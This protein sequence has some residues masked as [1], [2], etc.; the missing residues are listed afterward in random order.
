M[1]IPVQPP[2]IRY[3]NYPLLLNAVKDGFGVGLG[4]SLLVEQS[5]RDG[6]MIAVG[7]RVERKGYGYICRSRFLDNAVIAPVAER[8]AAK[9]NT[10]TGTS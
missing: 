3:R 5:I 8:L 2:R 4:W 1:N 6:T 10:P 9:M 7:P